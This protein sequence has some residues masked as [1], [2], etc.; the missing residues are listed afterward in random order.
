LICPANPWLNMSG[1]VNGALLQR[2]GQAVQDELHALLKSSGRRA[3]EAGTVVATGPGPL[4]VKWIVHAVAI[5]PFY[6]SSVDLVARTI[7]AALDR[8][9]ELG[10][11]TVVMPM[12]ATGYGRLT[13]RD[14]GAALARIQKKDWP[15]ID[16][17]T[18][19]VRSNNHLKILSDSLSFQ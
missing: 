19:V 16:R 4:A 6:D 9:V 8:I 15:A 2:G 18:V 7:A 11:R 17:L 14:F 13:T 3:V 1:G 12:L 10:E 5:D